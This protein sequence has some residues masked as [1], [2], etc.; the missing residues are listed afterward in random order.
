MPA[1]A[2]YMLGHYR[3]AVVIIPS[4]DLVIVRLGLTREGDWDHERD[5]APIVHAFP[6][7]DAVAEGQSLGGGGALRHSRLQSD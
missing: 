2:Y 1:D 5:L 6:A 7:N 3:Q 4:R